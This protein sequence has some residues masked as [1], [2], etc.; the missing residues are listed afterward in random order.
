[1][2]IFTWADN[3][4]VIVVIARYAEASTPIFV[5]SADMINHKIMFCQLHCMMNSDMNFP[6]FTSAQT[7]IL[8]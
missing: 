5:L 2:Q 4:V 7:Q 1:M 3:S 6:I 8:T